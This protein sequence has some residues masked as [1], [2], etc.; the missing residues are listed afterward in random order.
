MKRMISS[1]KNNILG[2]LL[3]IFCIFVSNTFINLYFLSNLSPDYDR[4]STYLGY[5]L[6][7]N[8][9]IFSEQGVLYYFVISVF[10]FFNINI[11]FKWV[12]KISIRTIYVAGFYF[13]V[14]FSN[15][16][17]SFNNTFCFIASKMSY[18]W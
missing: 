16:H 13:K 14:M 5:F 8:G 15:T 18:Q 1:K 10:I 4:Y 12:S 7:P 2:F 3:L 17:I 9:E 6:E 11:V